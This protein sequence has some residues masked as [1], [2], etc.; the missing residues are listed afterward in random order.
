MSVIYSKLDSHLESAPVYQQP[1]II[2][3]PPLETVKIASSETATGFL[4]IN[5]SDFD[6]SSMQEYVEP[7]DQK[8][9]K[10]PKTKPAKGAE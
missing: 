1:L 7:K 6:G 10:A 5:R 2:P 8:D 9:A 4:I 3:S